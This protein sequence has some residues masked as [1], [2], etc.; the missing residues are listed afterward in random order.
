MDMCVLQP[1]V[2]DPVEMDPD[3]ASEKKKIDPDP[4]SSLVKKPR[5]QIRPRARWPK[6]A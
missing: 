6:I 1:R 2:V 3:P 4:D 5:L